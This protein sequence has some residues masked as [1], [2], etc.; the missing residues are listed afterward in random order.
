[1]L[2]WAL[3]L[4]SF[5]LY[6]ER[7]SATTEEGG[8]LNAWLTSSLSNIGQLFVSL[9]VVVV[10]V[11]L[12]AALRKMKRGEASGSIP[13]IPSLLVLVVRFVI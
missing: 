6:T 8:F 9:Q 1:V 5:R 4:A 3:S 7:S 10:G 13:W 2:P 12:G 11:S